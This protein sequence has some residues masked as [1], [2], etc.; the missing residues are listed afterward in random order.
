MLYAMKAASRLRAR[1]LPR[2]VR[3]AAARPTLGTAL[4]NAILAA[5][6]VI[7]FPASALPVIAPSV[8]GQR[9]YA[10][11]RA[12]HRARIVTR[13][14]DEHEEELLGAFRPGE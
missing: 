2:R 8:T 12:R 9:R 13:R 6:P 3:V 1:T 10:Q 4:P 5:L 7:A 14:R 11:R